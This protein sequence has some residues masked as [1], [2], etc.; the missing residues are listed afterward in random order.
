MTQDPGVTPEAA[1]TPAAVPLP[2]QMKPRPTGPQTPGA[3]HPAAKPPA[4]MSPPVGD[5]ASEKFGRVD[6]DGN[7]FVTLPDGNEQFVGQWATGIPWK[8][9]GCMRA[10]TTI[11]WWT[12]T[13]PG[14][15]WLRAG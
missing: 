1:E 2:S 14:S 10:G 11:W 8:V 15:G 13:W 3:R 9:S 7:I 12:W 5:S 4:V 6:S